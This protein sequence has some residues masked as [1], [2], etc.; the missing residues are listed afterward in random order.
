MSGDVPQVAYFRGD[1]GWAIDRAVAGLA[2]GLERDTGATPDRWRT[3]GRETTPEAIGEHVATAPMFGGGTVAVVTDPGPLVRSKAGREAL[4]RVIAAVAPGNALV[5][6]ELGTDPR[7]RPK[8]LEELEGAVI[9]SG[10]TGRAFRAPQTGEMVGWVGARAAELG[11][12]L[13]RDAAK[14]LATRVGAFVTEGDIDRQRMGALAVGE[15]EKLSLYRPDGPVTV[16]DVRAL[17]PEAIPDSTW[18]FLDAIATRRVD[19]A[20]PLLDRLLE[21]TPEPVI[22]VQLHRRLRQLLIAADH[23]AAGG[24]PAALVKL[25]DAKPFVVEKTVAQARAWTPAELESALDGLLELDAMLK[26]VV[27][28][29]ATDRQRRMAW[30][31]WVGERVASGAGGDGRA[32]GPTER[33]GARRSA[34]RR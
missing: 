32:A 7:R 13:E 28:A 29:G 23:V 33:D 34:T 10:G 18:A 2:K 1:D 9:G 19:R 4:E 25:M 24:A 8:A 15:L 3:T 11:M 12:T 30:V 26:G 5:F 21:S 31:V 27:G 16:E 20:A 6:V 22:L 17:V 14:E